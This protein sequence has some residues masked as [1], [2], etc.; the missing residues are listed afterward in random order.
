MA[1]VDKIRGL[2]PV[3]TLNG[4]PYT[5]QGMLCYKPARTTVTHDLFVGDPVIMFGSA[6]AGGIINVEK[7]TLA[8]ANAIFGVIQGMK[9]DADNRD[10]GVWIDG[11]DT[12]YLYVCVDPMVIFEIQV[13]GAM[14]VTDIG[15]N[16]NLVQTSAGNRANGQSG[17]ELAATFETTAAHQCKVLGLV[18]RADNEINAVNNKALVI[19]NNHVFKGGTG[20]VGI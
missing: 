3:K 6:D 20:T 13:D 10:R 16:A 11:A 7:A 19:I 15:R 5:A 4:S 18:Q 9:F 12:G 2:R 1:N 8:T 14:A 17:I